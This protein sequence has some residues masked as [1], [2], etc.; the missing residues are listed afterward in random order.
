[1]NTKR[2]PDFIRPQ[3]M[4]S[5]EY[6]RNGDI[7]CDYYK[8]KGHNTDECFH[9]KKL[10]KKMIRARELNQFV[11]DLCDKLK[12]KENEKRKKLMPLNIEER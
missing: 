3:K 8:D 7:Y 4:K 12:P 1:M 11:K 6:T 2:K 10:I 5:F 9:L